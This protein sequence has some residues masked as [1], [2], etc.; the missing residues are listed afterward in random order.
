MANGRMKDAKANT[1]QEDQ[2]LLLAKL[3]QNQQFSSP[4]Q[5]QPPLPPL[6][7]RS[8]VTRPWFFFMHK[9]IFPVGIMEL[10]SLAE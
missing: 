3:R 2:R 8:R 10:H 6:L 9:N 4:H 7:I 5:Q 1:L